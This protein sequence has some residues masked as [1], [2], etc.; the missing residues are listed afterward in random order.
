MQITINASIPFIAQP[1]A[2]SVQS[3]KPA[4]LKI[5]ETN[6]NINCLPLNSYSICPTTLSSSL[7]GFPTTSEDAQIHL[8]SPRPTKFWKWKFSLYTIFKSMSWHLVRKATVCPR[9]PHAT[10]PKASF[11]HHDSDSLLFLNNQR[12]TAKAN[13]TLFPNQ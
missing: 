11:S 7:N 8:K 6:I 4:R 13:Q 3:T 10:V 2:I 1:C 12:L 5:W 9:S